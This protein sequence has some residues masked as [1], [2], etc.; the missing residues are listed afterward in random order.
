M[1]SLFGQFLEN[2]PLGIDASG[3]L[4]KREST[5]QKH[6]NVIYLDEPVGA[7][8]SNTKNPLGYARNLDGISRDMVIFLKQFL[9]MFPE[10]ENREFYVA[11]ESYGGTRSWRIILGSLTLPYKVSLFLSP[12]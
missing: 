12:L 8:Y 6:V 5:V 10:Y 7:G 2:G 11:G 4:F 3:S 1:S 9:I